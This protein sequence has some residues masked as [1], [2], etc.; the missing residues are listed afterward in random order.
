MS[1]EWT[2][3]YVTDVNYTYGYYAEL[4]PLRCRLPL[5]L[6]GRHAP[7][8]ENACELGFGQGLSVSIHAAAQ[9]NI[10]WYG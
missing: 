7:R 10:D 4:N 5:M 2:A 9:P 3:G 8:I 1:T 6:A